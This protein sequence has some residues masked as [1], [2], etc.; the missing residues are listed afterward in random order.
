MAHRGEI[1][2]RAARGFNRSKH[3]AKQ[4]LKIIPGNWPLFIS[5]SYGGNVAASIIA[6][7]YNGA[8]RILAAFCTEDLS[9]RRHLLEHTG[10][11]LAANAPHVTI[12]GAYERTTDK[13]LDWQT[14]ET[15]REVLGGEWVLVTKI[16]E[17]RR[18][19]VLDFLAR[20][21]PFTFEPALRIDGAHARPLVDAL[22]AR[23][24]YDKERRD[25]RDTSWHAANALSILLARLEL[26]K[27]MPKK[28]GP[29][30]IPPSAM[31]A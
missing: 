27:A 22:G 25:T 9:L 4:G 10:G 14:H 23:W 3:V 19:M 31:C 20:A 12:M 18:D 5:A 11:W 29:H 30:R 13:E 15:A 24:N 8:T 21:L 26:W 17:N 16:W 7:P 6:Q 28:P 1:G 2:K